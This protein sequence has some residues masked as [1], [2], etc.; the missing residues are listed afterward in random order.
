MRSIIE[1][2]KLDDAPYQRLHAGQAQTPVGQAWIVWD[3]IGIRELSLGTSA[4][5]L[6][7]PGDCVAFESSDDGAA[8]LLA[9]A[10]AG[11]L[12]RPIVLCGTA[13]ARQVW[14]ELTGLPLGQTVSYGELAKRVGTPG[15]ARA[16]GSAVG[17]NLI[18]FLV[19]CHRVV[20]ADGVIGEFRWGTDIKR[21]LLSWESEQV[22]TGTKV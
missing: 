17:R 2:N 5:L 16:V 3:D 22:N 10:F 19:P 1:I 21:S 4:E 14:R 11:R 18:G 9:E 13:F 8:A 6:K 12:R 7:T 20:R 15:G